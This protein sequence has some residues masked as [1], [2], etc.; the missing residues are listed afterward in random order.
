M[1]ASLVGFIGRSARLVVARALGQDLRNQTMKTRLLLVLLLIS[2]VAGCNDG[3]APDAR[4]DAVN[5]FLLGEVE[6]KY[7]LRDCMVVVNFEWRPE[8]TSSMKAEVVDEIISTMGEVTVVNPKMPL[9]SGHTTSGAS[10]FAFYYV[11]KCEDRAA[12]TKHFIDD[13]VRPISKNFPEYS[14]VSEGI[15]PGFDGVTLSGAWLPD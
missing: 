1:K 11:D 2:S 4:R 3:I 8:V 10:Y 13:F 12:L 6:P 7:A 14:I 5:R 9:F 15:E